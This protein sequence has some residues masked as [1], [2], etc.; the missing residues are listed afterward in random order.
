MSASCASLLTAILLMLLQ[1]PKGVGAMG[2]RIVV[3]PDMLVSRDGNVPHIETIVAAN[4][5]NPRNLVGAAIV[6]NRPEGGYACKTYTSFNGGITWFDS[7][8]REQMQQGGADPQVVFT[9]RGTALFMALG[10]K[11][12]SEEVTSLHVYRSEDGGRSWA[13]PIDLGPSSDYD[14]EQATV[15]TTGG[16]YQDRVYVGVGYADS[17]GVF[18][19][20]DDG[21]SFTGPVEAAKGAGKLNIGVENLLI[22][23]DGTLFVPYHGQG[24]EFRT[25]DREERP[26]FFVT[27][28]DGGLTFSSPQRVES[29]IISLTDPIHR[30][31]ENPQYAVDSLA[32]SRFKDHLYVVWTDCRHGRSRIL[33]STSNGRGVRWTA[34]RILDPTVPAAAGQFQPAIAVNAKGVVGVT[35]FDTRQTNRGLEYDEYF[36]ASVDGGQSFLSPVRVSS[37]SSDPE[38]PG[39]MI[40]FPAPGV[41][42][43]QLVLDLLS[44]AKRWGNGGDYMGLT[45]DSSGIFHPFW[46]DSRQGAFQVYTAKIEVVTNDEPR[47]ATAQPVEQAQVTGR[48]PTLVETSVLELVELVFDPAAYDASGREVRL[49]VRVKNTSQKTLYGPLR[50]EIVEFGT[51]PTRRLKENA[52]EV[53]NASNGKRGVGAT[54]D[55]TQM[56]GSFG[57]LEPGE[58]SGAIRWRLRLIDY[59]ETP[60]IRLSIVGSI[61]P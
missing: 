25:K 15:D 51:G 16:K 59:Y 60:Y 47:G 19:S 20:D 44:A 55:Y 35:W 58:I 42:G 12:H 29:Q 3:G 27:S 40:P 8:F 48:T 54:F 45:A 57:R 56:L 23:S 49:A 18:R 37:E 52:P 4:P 39:N 46:A 17:I 36:T 61:K 11:E 5:K 2:P 31:W 9:S 28:T 33:F 22:L 24:R 1:V 30:Y 41:E 53:L 43:Q 7:T 26:F 10:N 14:H 21:R 34:P 32:M 50:V 38:A 13:N 6:A